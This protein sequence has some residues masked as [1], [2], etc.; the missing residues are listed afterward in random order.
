[1]LDSSRDRNAKRDQGQV[2]G[3]GGVHFDSEQ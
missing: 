2:G 1:M 3:K